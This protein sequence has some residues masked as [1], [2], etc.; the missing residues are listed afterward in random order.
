MPRRRQPIWFCGSRATRPRP[1]MAD[2]CGSKAACSSRFQA[3]A[4]P[5]AH[6]HGGKHLLPPNKSSAMR[7]TNASQTSAWQR[8]VTFD[9]VGVVVALL[10]VC[11]LLCIAAGDQFLQSG[12]LLQV[13]RQSTSYGIMAVGM[14]LLL[15]MGQIDLSVGSILTLVNIVTA[16][17]LREG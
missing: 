10:C 12:N 3:G 5:P 16:I 17:A 2:F 14:V 1:S 9:E 6:S 15:S 4:M 8:L 11:G 13:A 7:D